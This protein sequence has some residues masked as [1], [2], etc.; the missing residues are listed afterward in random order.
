MV[1]KGRDNSDR[2]VLRPKYDVNME[3]NQRGNIDLDDPFEAAL[4]K[5]YRNNEELKPSSKKSIFI[6]IAILIL[7]I[8]AIIAIVIVY[9]SNNNNKDKEK[10]K[11]TEPVVTQKQKIDFASTIVSP[12]SYF[13]NLYSDTVT[14]VSA[15]TPNGEYYYYRIVKTDLGWLCD[16]CRY[17]SW[18]YDI[19]KEEVKIVYTDLRCWNNSTEQWTYYVVQ[20]NTDTITIKDKDNIGILKD[21]KRQTVSLTHDIVFASEKFNYLYS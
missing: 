3:S 2:V 18:T 12:A 1:D 9:L 15:F 6:I 17:G 13:E 4:S 10:N 20:N 8:S 7:L 16:D 21:S 5:K 19:S 14:F 11:T